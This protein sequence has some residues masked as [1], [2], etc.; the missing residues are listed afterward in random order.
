MPY[1]AMTNPHGGEATREA[2]RT[3]CDA[4]RVACCTSA[5]MIDAA[6]QALAAQDAA[7]LLALG[8]RGRTA[9]ERDIEREVS[10]YA[11]HRAGAMLSMWLMCA[12]MPDTELTHL[13]A[14]DRAAAIRYG[15]DG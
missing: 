10:R 2:F 15:L 13:A 5:A 12:G 8:P 1:P 4:A 14:Q 6:L 11:R 7:D 3:A 9:R